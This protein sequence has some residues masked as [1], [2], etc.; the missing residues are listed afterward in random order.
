MRQLEKHA[1]RRVRLNE[2]L[3]GAEAKA[4]RIGLAFDLNEPRQI[5]LYNFTPARH[6]PDHHGRQACANVR[7]GAVSLNL[8]AH[9]SESRGYWSDGSR[10]RQ[11]VSFRGLPHEPVMLFAFS[12]KLFSFF[13]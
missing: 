12:H 10:H 13:L 4:S 11:G 6:L 1:T 3:G 9:L 7:D 8:I 5:Y 2:M